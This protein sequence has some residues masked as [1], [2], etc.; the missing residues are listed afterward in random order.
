M[1]KRNR[2]LAKDWTGITVET[3]INKKLDVSY[4]VYIT[5]NDIAVISIDKKDGKIDNIELFDWFVLND[6]A[7]ENI[8]KQRVIGA[9]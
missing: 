9:I 4:Q 3:R 8:V 2:V 5:D 1:S 6:E 7:I